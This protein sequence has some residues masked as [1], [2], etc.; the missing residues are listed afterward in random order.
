MVVEL[1]WGFQTVAVGILTGV[2]VR[3]GVVAQDLVAITDTVVIG[4]LVDRPGVVLVQ[5]VSVVEP[6]AVGVWI[7][8]VGEAAQ[9]EVVGQTVSVGIDCGA[10]DCGNQ[11]G[12]GEQ[13][14]RDQARGESSPA[15]RRAS[16]DIRMGCSI[17][18][19]VLLLVYL[20]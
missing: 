17:L 14:S 7:L 13:C 12:A 5:L 16:A 6:V 18:D 1:F 20:N 8:R 4:V 2:V 9:F 15:S 11:H 3:V 10:G 19:M